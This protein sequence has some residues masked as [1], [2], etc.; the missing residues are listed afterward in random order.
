LFA[1]I[2]VKGPQVNAVVTVPE[3]AIVPRG[4]DAFVY[5]VIDGKALETKVR[6][7]ERKAGHVEILEGI[8]VDAI[9]VTAGQQR[10]KH[11]ATVEVISFDPRVP[12]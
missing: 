6:V 4:T 5:R 8:A 11:G 9:V 1:R 10:L 3:S 7:G 2:N 12:G